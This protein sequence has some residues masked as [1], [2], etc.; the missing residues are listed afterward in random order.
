M[1]FTVRMKNLFKIDNILTTLINLIK[2]IKMW[3]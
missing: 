1:I 2:L 3:M